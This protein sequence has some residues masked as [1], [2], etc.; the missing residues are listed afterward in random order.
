MVK[1]NIALLGFMGTGKTSVS[2]ALAKKLGIEY[3]ETDRLIENR[4]GKPIAQIFKE[5]G[6]ATFRELETTIIKEIAERDNVIISCG[7]GIVLNNENTI[8]LKKKAIIVLLTASPEVIWERI[9]KTNERPLLDIPNKLERIQMLLD[10]RDPLYQSA[11][12]LV[13]DTDLLTVDEVTNIIIE[14]ISKSTN[15]RK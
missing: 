11:A 15:Y 8:T 6:E 7:G 9:S 2:K 4:V 5:D 13:I 12:D 10:F 3:I 1:T 14:E